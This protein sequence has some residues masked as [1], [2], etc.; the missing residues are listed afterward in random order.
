MLDLT[1]DD[2]HLRADGVSRSMLEDFREDPAWFRGLYVSKEFARPPA[3]A[4]MLFG[5]MVHSVLLENALD[6]S[7]VEIPASA[8]NGD[9][10]RKG[11]GWKSFCADLAPGAVAMKADEIAPLKAIRR[12][13]E[14][15]PVARK[16]LLE[17]RGEAEVTFEWRDDATGL[18]LKVRLDW[19][20]EPH[21]S[22]PACIVDVKTTGRIDPKS[23]A[24]TCWRYGYHRQA[25]FYRM[26]VE[27]WHL[28]RLPFVFVA[29][30][31]TPPYSVACFELNEDAPD[32]FLPLGETQVVD[33][34]ADLAKR[35]DSGDWSALATDQI[36]TLPAPRWAKYESEYAL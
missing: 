11:A 29:V 7:I 31:K 33:A 23:F 4:D 13:V 26:G 6:D 30:R 34:L 28:E 27:T 21:G 2:Y 8:L 17:A 10:H 1:A 9:G 32:G 25:A 16:L 3:T 15:H 35:R 36:F 20:T 19:M 5:S 14:S 18:L 24:E 12:N 22:L